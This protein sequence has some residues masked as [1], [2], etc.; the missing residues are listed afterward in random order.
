M[1]RV[2]RTNPDTH[3]LVEL[4]SESAGTSTSFSSRSFARLPSWC[5]D[6]MI[7]VPPTNSLLTYSCGMVG[8]SE[9]SLMPANGQHL[10]VI[11]LALPMV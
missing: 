9:Y 2:Y 5:M 10:C 11:F 4:E 7:S 6:I 1:N 8:Q 3:E